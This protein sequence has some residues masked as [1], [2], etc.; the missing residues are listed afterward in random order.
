MTSTMEVKLK[1]DLD[2]GELNSSNVTCFGYCLE[3]G[4]VVFSEESIPALL[5]IQG[6]QS[7]SYMYKTI[8]VAKVIS[9]SYIKNC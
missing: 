9:F 7:C 8:G 4:R 1:E 3:N 2:I 5:L 6:Y